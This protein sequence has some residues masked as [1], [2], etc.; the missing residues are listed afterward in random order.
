MIPTFFRRRTILT[1]PAAVGL[2]TAW[3]IAT[4]QAAAVESPF[5]APPVA[6]AAPDADDE[7]AATRALTEQ[8][9][10]MVSKLGLADAEQ[11]TR[12][13]ELVVQQSRGLR[14][15]HDARDAKI[16]E[17]PKTPGADP[18]VR[19]AWI[20]VAKSD[21]EHKLLLLHRRFVAR[22]AA[23]LTPEQVDQVKNGLTYGVVPITY[24]RY[25]RLLPKLT[26]EQQR[27][28][29][30][31]LLEAREVAMDAG[32]ADE[33]RAIFGQYQDKINNYLSAAGYDLKQAERE[34]A[35][36]E[37]TKGQQDSP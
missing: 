12:V 16:A 13:R 33:M 27:E 21:A 26:G 7:A 30:A 34:L 18:V 2:V 19:N 17:A 22:L 31:N 3:S 32:S 10:K 24:E 20:G 37:K 5:E 28:I 1:C 14:A 35:A 4:I 15:I 8:L 29:L 11:A 6:A 36:R 9:D 23:E 25:L